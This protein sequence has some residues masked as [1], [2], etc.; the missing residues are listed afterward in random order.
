[1]IR[2]FLRMFRSIYF[3]LIALAVI[4][5]VAAWYFAPYIGTDDWHPFASLTA[6][7]V[8]IACIWVFFMAIMLTVFLVRRHRAKKMTEEMAEAADPVEDDVVGE[9]IGELRGKFKA[10]MA[11]LRKSKNGKKHLNELPWYVMIGP[12]GA[13]KTTAIVNSGLQFPLADKMGKAAVGGVGGTRNC[14]WWFTNEAVLID[15]AGRY[16]TQEMEDA[17]TEMD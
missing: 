9:E 17:G 6:R 4:L 10:A 14:D 13:G 16:T 8:T 5:S 2:L 12:P 3:V 7:I 11:E 1:M 15:T